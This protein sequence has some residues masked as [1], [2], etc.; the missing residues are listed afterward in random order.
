M[1]ALVAENVASQIIDGNQSIMGIM[2][3]SHL[4]PVISRSRQTAR[5]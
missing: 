5:S 2:L 3:E 4:F 1:Q